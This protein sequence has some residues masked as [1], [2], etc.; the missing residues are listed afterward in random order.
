VFIHKSDDVPGD[1]VI[2]LWTYLIEGRGFMHTRRHNISTILK[3]FEIPETAR[4]T[5]VGLV[6]PQARQSLYVPESEQAFIWHHTGGDRWHLLHT[7]QTL[8][9]I[10]RRLSPGGIL[11][12]FQISEQE[13]TRTLNLVMDKLELPFS[14]VHIFYPGPD[15]PLEVP[16]AVFVKEGGKPQSDPLPWRMIESISPSHLRGPAVLQRAA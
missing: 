16:V 11:I 9:Q 2:P 4:V 8:R 12:Y 3:A 10:L 5:Q 14:E 13:L 6:Q 1:P 15:A 7:E